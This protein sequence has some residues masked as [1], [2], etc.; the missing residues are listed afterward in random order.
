MK[1]IDGTPKSLR[2]LFTGVKY[3]I[4]YYQREY[5]RQTKQIV[6]LLDDLME[7]FLG[8]YLTNNERRQGIKEESKLKFL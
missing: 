2:E 5:Q 8:Y 4:H 6:E 7:E 3:T 1:K